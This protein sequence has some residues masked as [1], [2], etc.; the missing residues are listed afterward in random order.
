MYLLLC[1]LL[2]H[3][4]LPELRQILHRL[5]GCLDRDTRCHLSCGSC[6]ICRDSQLRRDILLH[7]L[8][9]L[10]W[11]R[12]M[13]E[14]VLRHRLRLG[15]DMSNQMVFVRRRYDAGAFVRAS[16]ASRSALTLLGASFSACPPPLFSVRS[17]ITECRHGCSGVWC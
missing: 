6:V 7:L 16:Q 9:H 12:H 8:W 4:L 5:H 1:H 10:H 2:C 3:L 14:H 15:I 11:H 17:I 13:R